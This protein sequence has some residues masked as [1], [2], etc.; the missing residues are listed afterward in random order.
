[1]HVEQKSRLSQQIQQNHSVFWFILLEGKE[2]QVQL[3]QEG[4]EYQPRSPAESMSHQS[5][6]GGGL[7]IIPGGSLKGPCCTV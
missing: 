4:G 7:E 2:N 3:K 5:S 1:M 6:L